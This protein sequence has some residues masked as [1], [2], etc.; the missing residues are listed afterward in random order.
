MTGPLGA[1]ATVFD[2]GLKRAVRVTACV[3]VAGFGDAV[4]VPL[5]LTRFETGTLTD[6]EQ[7][8]AEP[9]TLHTEADTDVDDVESAGRPLISWLYE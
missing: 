2:D 1:P 8:E 6:A 5:L 3:G 7:N 4:K 9:A